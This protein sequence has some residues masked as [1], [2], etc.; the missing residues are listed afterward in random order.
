MAH[1]S[2]DLWVFAYGSLMWRPGFPVEEVAH[3]RLTGWRRSFCIYSRF[4][5]GSERRPGL[6]LGLDRGGACEGLAFRVG[7]CDAAATLAYLRE[8]EQVISVY[9]EALVPV[10]LLNAGRAEVMALAFLVE[11][12]HPSYAGVLPLA[13]QAHLIRGARGRSGNNIDYLVNTLA[14]LRAL[15]IRERDMERLKGLVGAHAARGEAVGHVRASA[16]GL[17]AECGKRPVRARRL[18]P[19]DARRFSYR[20]V[21]G[22]R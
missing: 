4:H 16:K 3:A 8:R 17:T 22:V 1:S 20:N 10:T 14:H 6:V 2:R 5:R 15:G 12:A 11:R 13:E 18:K 19:E 9:R 21:L 7:H